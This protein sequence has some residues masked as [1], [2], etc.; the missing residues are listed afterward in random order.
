[1]FDAQ[2]RPFM[3]WLLNPAA[4][5]KAACGVKTNHI[6]IIGCLLGL[7]TAVL[8]AF[9]L[10]AIALCLVPLSRFADGLDGAIFRARRPTDFGGY[11]GIVCDFV[12]YVAIAFSV[13]AGEPENALAAAF[14]IFIS[15]GMANSFLAFAVLPQ[16]HNISTEI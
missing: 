12:F 8:V 14:L 16:K 13:P 6:D 4:E 1:M 3:D 5:G 15:I 11:Q 2:I 7:S 9:Q 10:F